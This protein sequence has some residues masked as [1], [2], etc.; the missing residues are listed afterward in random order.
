MTSHQ[1]IYNH[2][3]VDLNRLSEENRR[4]RER[5]EAMRRKKA[6]ERAAKSNQIYCC[7]YNGCN[8]IFT[9]LGVY[10]KHRKTH[11]KKYRCTYIHTGCNREFAT[12][13]ALEIHERIHSKER[14]EIC[15]FCLRSFTDPAALRK[16]IKYIHKNDNCNNE[17]SGNGINIKPFRCKHCKKQFDRKDSLQ[18]HWRTHAKIGDEQKSFC[19]ICNKSFTFKFNYRKHQ[20]LYHPDYN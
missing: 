4:R 10:N 5:E 17:K 12:R 20:R 13:K 15:K 14:T 8:K 19:Q 11:I 18:K 16:H 1:W 6:E 2:R 7:D 9:R 3:K